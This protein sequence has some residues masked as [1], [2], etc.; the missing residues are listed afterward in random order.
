MN[1]WSYDYLLA[2]D[3]ENCKKRGDERAQIKSQV[4]KSIQEI[5]KTYKFTNDVK[6][7]F[8]EDWEGFCNY[9]I[10]AYTESI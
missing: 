10:W 9:I 4:D 6:S 8:D 5:V 3:N 2:T 7:Y 1:G